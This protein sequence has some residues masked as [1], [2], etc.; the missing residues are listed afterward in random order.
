MEEITNFVTNYFDDEVDTKTRDLPR[1]MIRVYQAK[2]DAGYA[3]NEGTVRFLD[4]R[5]H[6]VAHASVL[7]NCGL[8]KEYEWCVTT[9]YICF[10]LYLFF[11]RDCVFK[12]YRIFEVEM[13]Q[14][15]PRVWIGE[16]WT[17]NEEKFQD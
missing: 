1:N 17:K 5:D 8:L 3:P 11:N 12:L 4:N 10:I 13:V 6:R 16:V 2:A 14:R 15:D 7:S 9:S